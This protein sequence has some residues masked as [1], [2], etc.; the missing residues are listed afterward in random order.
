MATGAPQGV[1]A[2]PVRI[3]ALT[4]PAG[5]V[6]VGIVQARSARVR[7]D[8]IMPE[9]ARQVAARGGNFGKIDDITTSY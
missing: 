8:E 7:I 5:A 3:S 9:F 1:N 2:G 6:Q 4:I